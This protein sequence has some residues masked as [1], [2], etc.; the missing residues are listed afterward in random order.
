MDKIT[1]L[2]RFFSPY[3]GVWFR[4]IRRTR[5]GG[6]ALYFSFGSSSRRTLGDV[7]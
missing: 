2:S 6:A 1:N 7:A 3:G 5:V 4:V